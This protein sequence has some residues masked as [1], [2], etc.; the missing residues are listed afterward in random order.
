MVKKMKFQ[1][2]TIKE[3]GVDFAIVI[4]KEFVLRNSSKADEM[5]RTFQ[6][7]FPGIPV[8]LMAQDSRGVPSYY[9]RKDIANFMA[10]VP[11]QAVHW[12]EYTI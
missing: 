9:G 11:I 2:A 1:G 5:I 7:T 12:K 8:V 4:V 3:Q 6:P 10:N